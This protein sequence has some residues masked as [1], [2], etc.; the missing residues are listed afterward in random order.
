MTYSRDPFERLRGA[1]PARQHKPASPDSSEAQAMYQRIVTSDAASSRPM[2]R[3][4]RRV[5]LV[6]GVALLM[7]A[8]TYL[9]TRPVTEPLTVGCYR[10]AS[11]TADRVVI[12]A[13]S[14]ARAEELCRVAWEPGGEFASDSGGIPPPLTS[15]VLDSG[16]LGVF[17]SA[18]SGD[19]CQQLDIAPP[20]TSLIENGNELIDLQDALVGQFL[21]VCLDQQA[22]TAIVQ[23]ELDSRGLEDWRVTNAQPFTADRPCASL[24][25]DPNTL[26]VELVPISP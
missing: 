14:D 4:W 2:A 3:R 17:P 26:T 24:A 5:A 12:P 21:D 7:V 15:C 13:S 25:I 16:A 20:D 9:L 8:A 19:L 1:D 18:E 11:L 6:V 22:G 23:R 10:S